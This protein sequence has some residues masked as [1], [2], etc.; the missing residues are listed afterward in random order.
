MRVFE[1]QIRQIGETQYDNGFEVEI[2]LE[3]GRRIEV[4]SGAALQ[5]DDENVVVDLYADDETPEEI[6]DYAVLD[7]DP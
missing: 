7:S 5:I 1:P 3:D 6:T 2:V 4:R